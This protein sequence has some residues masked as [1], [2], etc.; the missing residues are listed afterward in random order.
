MNHSRTETDTRPATADIGQLREALAESAYGITPSGPPLAAIERHG[1]RIRRRRRTAVLGTGCGLLL[2]PLAALAL[3]GTHGDAGR[4]MP[5]AASASAS[6]SVGVGKVRVVTPGERVA[7]APGTRLWLTPDGLHWTEPD[8]PVQFKSVT[9]GNIA[10][11]RPGIETRTYG[12]NGDRFLFGT[13]HGKGEAARVRIETVGGDIEGTA[14][15]L[16]GSP[17]WGAWYAT[18][19][20]PSAALDKLSKDPTL[21]DG[22]RRVTVYDAVGGVIARTDVLP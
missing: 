6:P 19:K 7:A 9:D 18:V 3:R 10:L 20:L 8:A 2:V 21:D 15:T 1:R 16:A 12:S 4:V 22:T 14:L 17:G 5:P 13:Y 11:D